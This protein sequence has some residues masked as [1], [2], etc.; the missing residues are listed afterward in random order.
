MSPIPVSEMQFMAIL[1]AA[2][3]LSGCGCDRDAFVS[4]VYRELHGKQV[5]DGSVGLTIRAVQVN[6]PPPKKPS[7]WDRDRPRFERLAK[8]S[9]A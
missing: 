7:R 6:F 1:N 9:V 4:A 3:A 5:G 8:R 2:K